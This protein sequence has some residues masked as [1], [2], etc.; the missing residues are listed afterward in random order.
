MRLR[1]AVAIRHLCTPFAVDRGTCVQ[2][3][4]PRSPPH[5]HK[6]YSSNHGEGPGGSVRGRTWSSNRAIDRFGL[7]AF[8]GIVEA[9]TPAASSESGVVVPVPQ[10]AQFEA[11]SSVGRLVVDHRAPLMMKDPEPQSAQANPL[12]SITRRS[13]SGDVHAYATGIVLGRQTRRLRCPSSPRPGHQ[14]PR[15]PPAWGTR[16]RVPSPRSPAPADSMPKTPMRRSPM[17]E[18]PV[19]RTPR[20]KWT[21]GTWTQRRTLRR[22]QSRARTRHR[23]GPPPVCRSRPPSRSLLLGSPQALPG[24]HPHGP[25]PWW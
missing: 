23:R 20:Q 2:D 21:L 18:V 19:T 8:L 1:V 14:S 15:N 25:L 7:E 17:S 22:K 5:L 11:T 4:T 9:A 12:T 3:A 24:R 16:R 13:F 10:L 6:L